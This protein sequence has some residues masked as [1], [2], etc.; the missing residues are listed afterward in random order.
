MNDRQRAL[1]EWRE[2]YEHGAAAAGPL[3][4]PH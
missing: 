2:M 4:D 3:S 1:D